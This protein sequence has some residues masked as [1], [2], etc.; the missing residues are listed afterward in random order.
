MTQFN[1]K[2]AMVS[3]A[4]NVV[5]IGWKIKGTKTAANVEQC[6]FQGR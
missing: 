4:K 5:K 3:A 1:V 2:N 6:S